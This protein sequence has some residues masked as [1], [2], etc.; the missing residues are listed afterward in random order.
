MVSSFQ[1]LQPKFCMHFSS[2]RAFYMPR[3]PVVLELIMLI[4]FAEEY[5]FNYEAPHYAV[6]SS[7]LSLYPS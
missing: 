6:F 1:D 3:H 7:L 2:P 4:T 5:K